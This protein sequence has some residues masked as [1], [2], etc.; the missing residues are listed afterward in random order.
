MV[1]RTDGLGERIL[2]GSSSP[3]CN[4]AEATRRGAACVRSTLVWVTGPGDR[5]S[6]QPM[7]ERLAVV[8]IDFH[9]SEISIRREL[10]M[11]DRGY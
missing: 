4:A 2:S 5:K 3:Y 9:Y 8:L 10:L 11:I 6:I 7:A 1:G